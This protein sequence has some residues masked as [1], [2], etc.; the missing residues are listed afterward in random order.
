[1]A[2]FLNRPIC[3]NGEHD[4]RGC[5][6]CVF[7]F[8]VRVLDFH[9]LSARVRDASKTET[10][11]GSDFGSRMGVGGSADSLCCREHLA[12]QPAK[13][14][15]AS[16]AIPG[17]GGGKHGLAYGLWIY[18]AFLWAAVG[19]S[20]ILDH[21]SKL[22]VGEEVG[23]RVSISLRSCVFRVVVSHDRDGRVVAADAFSANRAFSDA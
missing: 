11:W 15:L 6:G 22:G 23:Q 16:A 7:V 10:T 18:G 8:E 20:D 4:V 5:P 13:V 3:P 9:K 2:L 14:A 21:G 17:A 12:R 19:L 1:V